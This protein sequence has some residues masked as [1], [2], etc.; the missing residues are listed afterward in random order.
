M[1]CLPRLVMYSKLS[2]EVNPQYGW[3]LTTNSNA[4]GIER[5]LQ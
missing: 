4:T 3:G 5:P 1:K 2:Y